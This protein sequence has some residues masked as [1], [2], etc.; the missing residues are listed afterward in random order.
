MPY[1]KTNVNGLQQQWIKIS[2]YLAI[3][4]KYMCTWTFEKYMGT[5]LLFSSNTPT[6]GDYF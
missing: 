2:F 5:D 3:Q 6:R 4:I 1:V